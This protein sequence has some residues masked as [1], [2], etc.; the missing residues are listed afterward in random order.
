[1]ELRRPRIKH[2]FGISQIQ[3]V[4][5]LDMHLHIGDVR[6]KAAFDFP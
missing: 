3:L 2:V 6:G 4:D 1:M 5:K